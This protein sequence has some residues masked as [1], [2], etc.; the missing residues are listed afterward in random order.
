ML[1]KLF[2]IFIILVFTNPAMATMQKDADRLFDWAAQNLPTYFSPASGQSQQYDV[3][4][5]RYY[6]LTESY[7][8]VNDKKEVYIVGRD[9]PLIYVGTLDDVMSKLGISSG[10]E[11]VNGGSA[12]NTGGC[13]MDM[14]IGMVVCLQGSDV[15]ASTMKGVCEGLGGQYSSSGCPPDAAVKCQ[16][17]ND[18]YTYI[19]HYYENA[20][21]STDSMEGMCRSDGGTVIH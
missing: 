14:G 4:Y 17:N 7:I 3:W 1:K 9:F 6:N 21:Y 20:N 19:W 10:Q 5:F 16:E 2:F 13:T 8:G 11:P 15:P 18:G 12:D